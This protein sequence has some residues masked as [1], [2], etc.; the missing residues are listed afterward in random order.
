MTFVLFE[1]SVA[2]NVSS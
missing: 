1:V 2:S